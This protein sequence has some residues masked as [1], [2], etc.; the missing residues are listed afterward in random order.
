M[1]NRYYDLRG[2]IGY[3]RPVDIDG[4]PVEKT[5]S[6]APYSYSFHVVHRDGPNENFNSMVYSDRMRQ[7]DFSKYER[8]CREA[9]SR[10]GQNFSIQHP[11]EVER[12]LQL[13]FEDF[14]IKLIVIME[15]CNV[16]SGYPLWTFHYFQ[17]PSK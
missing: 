6:E 12:F 2:R 9:F 5:K 7:W 4:K 8:C 1:D 3:A 14:S 16:S 15:G 11:K 10:K 17:E 13:Y